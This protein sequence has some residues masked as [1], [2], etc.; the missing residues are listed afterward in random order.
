M[1]LKAI[2]KIF[3][4]KILRKKFC[5]KKN[6]M[7]EMNLDKKKIQKFSEVPKF[8]YFLKVM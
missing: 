5:Q 8:R 1:V 7:I 2:K 4:K 6:S 3:E